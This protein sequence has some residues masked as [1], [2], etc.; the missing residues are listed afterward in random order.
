VSIEIAYI[1]Y[2]HILEFLEGEHG[3]MNTRV[4]WNIHKNLPP[5]KDA[6]SI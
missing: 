2:A 4:E 1:P 3:N 6:L 5:Q